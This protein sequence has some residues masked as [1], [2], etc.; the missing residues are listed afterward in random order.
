MRQ[1]DT[2]TPER[3]WAQI[4]EKQLLLENELNK[5]AD[6][7]ENLGSYA[8]DDDIYEYESF[9]LQIE[10]RMHFLD[11][12]RDFAVVMT[13]PDVNHRNGGCRKREKL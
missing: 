12:T 8:S 6:W 1:V 2:H 3:L 7:I 10:R 5:A 13:T 9:K 11:L 4:D